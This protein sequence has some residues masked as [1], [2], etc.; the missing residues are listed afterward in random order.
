MCEC[1][2]SCRRPSQVSQVTHVDKVIK[3]ED[4]SLEGFKRQC[5]GLETGFTP[6]MSIQDYVQTSM[7]F[8]IMTFPFVEAQLDDVIFGCY[9]SELHF[10]ANEKRPR[11]KSGRS[12]PICNS[13][14][15]P[16]HSSPATMLT[17][18]RDI[19][20]IPPPTIGKQCTE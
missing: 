14:S 6:L 4:L 1:F 8:A 16:C 11:W 3:V 9:S 10:G 19:P 17:R 13:P 20:D 7:I 12:C 18:S 5:E 2:E 15:R